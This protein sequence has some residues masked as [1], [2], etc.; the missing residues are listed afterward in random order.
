M[1]LD[2]KKVLITV[3]SA[4]LINMLTTF[5]MDIIKYPEHKIEKAISRV[6]QTFL[7]DFSD[8]E[9]TTPKVDTTK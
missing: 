6:H 3:A 7:W 1:N 8:K 4:V 2:F 9:C 5:V